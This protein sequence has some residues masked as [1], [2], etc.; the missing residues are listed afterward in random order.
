MVRDN[1]IVSWV[2]GIYIYLSPFHPPTGNSIAGGSGIPSSMTYIAVY[3]RAR[4][5][6]DFVSVAVGLLGN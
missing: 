6:V 5:R 3:C 2:D 1:G 4:A